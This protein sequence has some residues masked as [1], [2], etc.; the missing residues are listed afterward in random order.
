MTTQPP[1]QE[2]TLTV[3]ATI[4]GFPTE[5]CFSGS[6]DQLL[7]VTK[8]LRALGA[9]PTIAPAAPAAAPARKPAQR[10]EPAYDGNGEPCCPKHNRA[11]K[12]GQY[13]LYCS[14]KDDSTE[15]GFCSLKFKD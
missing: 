15:R 9:S 1:R 7:D 14:A 8:R 3:H 10:V 6:I 13:G 4:D 5:V 11:L 12:E 2:L